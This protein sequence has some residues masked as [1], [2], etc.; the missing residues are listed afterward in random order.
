MQ[1]RTN[2]GTN[3]NHSLQYLIAIAASIGSA[4]LLVACYCICRYRMN[5]SLSHDRFL[6]SIK[7]AD[8]IN[9]RIPYESLYD[10]HIP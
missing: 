9:N 2:T 3:H 5:P 10:M 4:I 6:N 7:P 8:T 1:N